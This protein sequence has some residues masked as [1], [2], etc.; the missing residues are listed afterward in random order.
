MSIGLT[1]GS[2]ES[3]P[4]DSSGKIHTTT[5]YGEA[6]SVFHNMLL[7]LKDII[8]VNHVSKQLGDHNREVPKHI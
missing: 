7:K 1:R 2:S 3:R 8:K 4:S 6:Q 5:D